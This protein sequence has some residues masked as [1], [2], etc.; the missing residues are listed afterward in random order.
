MTSG[1]VLIIIW[2]AIAPVLLKAVDT[3]EEIIVAGRREYRYKFM[4]ALI[5]FLPIIIMAGMRGS[6]GDTDAYRKMFQDMPQTFAVLPHY[7]ETLEKDKGFFLCSSIIKIIIGN[8][9]K[10]YFLI[11]A[12]IQ[13]ISLVIAYRKFSSNYVMSILLFLISSDYISWMFNG[14]RQFIAVSVTFACIGL[15][16]DNKRVKLIITILL[17][18]TIH[19]TA[20][21]MIPFVF[22]A[23]GRAW[24]K[25]TMLFI[26]AVVL[27]VVFVGRF[28]N[29]LDTALADTQYEN[30]VS[31]WEEFQD[32]GT[33][34]LRV[35]VY[36]IPTILSYIGRRK[37][38]EEDNPVINLCANMSIVSTGLYVV[39]MFTSGIMIGRLPIYFS[40]Y[41]YIL[42]PWEI[43]NLFTERSKKIVY[44]FMIL[45]YIV[46]YYYQ[47]H[48][49]WNYF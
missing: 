5:I 28:T 36:A 11:I 29:L 18:A 48:M 6:V 27:A 13:G 32:D 25:K 8:N 20:L 46:F 12:F 3:H 14:M 17:M 45:A 19:G 41:N 30:V 49:T 1:Y 35:L 16:L 47:M 31:D 33:S 9:D 34:A 43:E 26:I 21:M 40:L 22:M 23:K 37:I 44:I 42:L 2:I 4:W 24:N 7:F 10:I 39:S 15:I 38:W